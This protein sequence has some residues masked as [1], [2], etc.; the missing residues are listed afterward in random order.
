MSALEARIRQAEQSAKEDRRVLL[1]LERKIKVSERKL[2]AKEAK[3]EMMEVARQKTGSKTQ[4]KST[5]T[6]S[7]PRTGTPL[8]MSAHE[9]DDA[10][11]ET[12][13]KIKTRCSEVREKWLAHKRECDRQ[14]AFALRRDV[15]PLDVIFGTSQGLCRRS[16]AT[17]RTL[18]VRRL[19]GQS[20][21]SI[22]KE[23]QC[24]RQSQEYMQFK[25]S[26]SFATLKRVLLD[27]SM[28]P[29]LNRRFTDEIR[30]DLSKN[31]VHKLFR[32][33]VCD[34]CQRRRFHC[35]G[36]FKYTTWI[37]EF[38]NISSPTSCCSKFFCWECLATSI[39]SSLDITELWKSSGSRLRLK[40]PGQCSEK[41]T[42]INHRQ[43]LERIIKEFD[44]TRS[45][46]ILTE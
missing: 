8:I 18:L 28:S 39:E 35:A 46:K 13:L 4:V 36:Q 10:Y 37:D 24:V 23:P 41:L 33:Q 25:A 20:S 34:G 2:H 6:S 9:S 32:V 11:L 19:T 26:P 14:M 45:S 7:L 40:C 5:G 17:P 21:L 29:D 22:A 30:D 44:H 1:R 15:R 31:E 42:R 16:F 38:P 27:V 43:H 3:M 12:I